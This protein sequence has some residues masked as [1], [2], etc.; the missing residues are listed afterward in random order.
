M[1]KKGFVIACFALFFMLGFMVFASAQA[2]ESEDSLDR[3]YKCL[4]NEIDKK[5]E[6]SL[7][8]AVFSVLAIGAKSGLIDS[9][10]SYKDPATCWPKGACE[11]KDT[12]QV[13]LAYKRVNK[14]SSA[15]KGWLLDKNKTAT[16]LRWLLEIDIVNRLAAQCT[17][18]DG[19]RDNTIRILDDM[20]IQ[21]SPGPC[22]TIDEGGYML[23]INN[24]CLKSDFEISCD[25]DFVTSILY[26]KSVGGT[27]YVLPEAH[28]AAS[29]GRTTERANGECF[30]KGTTCDYEGTL[31]ATLAL[32]KMGDDISRFTPY[33]L[34]F[35]EDNGR[36]FPAAFLYIIVGGDDQYNLIIQQQKQG[37]FWEMTGTR[38][39]RY[40]DTSLALLALADRGGAEVDATHEYL[41]QIQTKDGCWNNN[42]IRDTAFLLYSG[43]PKSVPGF[44]GISSAPS[45]EPNLACENRF[46]CEQAG[47]TVEHNYECQSL[48][49]VCCSIRVSE[50]PCEQRGG[51]LCPTGKQCDGRVGPSSDGPCCFGT[52]CIDI[53]EPAENRCT[54]AGGVCKS[55]CSDDEE[56]TGDTCSLSDEVCC[57]ESGGISW[58]WII[59]LIILVALIVLGIIYRQKVKIWWFQIKEKVKTRFGKKKEPPKPLP[60]PQRP[61]MPFAASGRP[62]MTAPQTRPVMRPIRRVQKD[63]ELEEALKRLR[64]MGNKK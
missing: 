1:K 51:L 46:D 35:A 29:L 20:K 21:G 60:L 33:L 40:H 12:A 6:L 41:L 36:Y 16:E 15:V 34:A 42:N 63:K 25:Q 17:I 24:N 43:W 3:A 44:G 31:W 49:E 7:K 47:G 9:I 8:E 57:I 53:P 56:E 28:S 4:E 59:L 5:S 11:I 26:Q 48:G 37:K 19:T 2:N 45:C 62:I 14:D 10:E 30:K 13:A 22:F 55:Y 50:L 58:F 38:D 32:E 27:I 18:N 23:K 54:P 52:S 61:G 64:E 39:G